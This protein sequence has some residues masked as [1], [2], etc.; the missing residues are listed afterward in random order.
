MRGDGHMPPPSHFRQPT[1]PASKHSQALV[2][3]QTTGAA[4]LDAAAAALASLAPGA[5]A[6][7]RH[8]AVT[9]LLRQCPSP[10]L[11]AYVEGKAWR[12]SAKTADVI[13]DAVV[14]CVD[15]AAVAEKAAAAAD[16]LLATV[17]RRCVEAGDGTNDDLL[18]ATAAIAALADA[19]AAALDLRRRVAA[20]L[21]VD[22]DADDVAGVA[23]A[24]RLTPGV[25]D[26]DV[27]AALRVEREE[28]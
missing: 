11:A 23:L 27:E 4:A 15:G 22:A 19:A 21:G 24:W 28:K 12:S 6:H 8:P 26:E 16:A 7:R 3:T 1:H 10:Q 5:D 18:A 25:A 17:Q 2:L 9:R 20:W 14:A 13:S